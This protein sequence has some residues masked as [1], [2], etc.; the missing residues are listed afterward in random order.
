MRFFYLVF[1]LMVCCQAK[2]VPEDGIYA[3]SETMPDY[4][5][6]MGEFQQ[7]MTQEINKLTAETKGSIFLSF[8]VKANGELDH[9]AVINGVNEDL[10][11]KAINILK[12][13]PGKWIPGME[14]GQPVDVRMVYPIRF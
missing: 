14:E 2:Y 1:I 10:D 6:G 5:N 11:N 13:A 12:N 4:E 8:V 9:V 7:Y 3:V